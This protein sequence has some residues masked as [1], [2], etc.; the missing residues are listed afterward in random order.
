MIGLVVRRGGEL[1]F[2]GWRK[3]LGSASLVFVAGQDRVDVVAELES[4]CR[5]GLSASGVIRLNLHGEGDG[6]HNPMLVL[7]FG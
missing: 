4:H 6:L 7:P 5:L 3:D 1:D 2:A